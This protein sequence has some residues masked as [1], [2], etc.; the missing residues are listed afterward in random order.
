MWSLCIK[1][2]IPS[3]SSLRGVEVPVPDACTVGQWKQMLGEGCLGD[4]ILHLGICRETLDDTI[5]DS[6][7]DF[8][9]SEVNKRSVVLCPYPILL[10]LGFLLLLFVVPAISLNKIRCSRYQD[11]DA[12]KPKH[13]NDNSSPFNRLPETNTYTGMTNY[14]LMDHTWTR[15]WHTHT[16]H[17]HRHSWLQWTRDD[18]SWW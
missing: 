10:V 15:C 13:L 7:S 2:G 11:F 8:H 16:C 1:Q 6:W 9:C 12:R 14:T 4:K 17:M 5:F 18:E 3:W